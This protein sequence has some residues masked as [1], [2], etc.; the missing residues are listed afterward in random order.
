MKNYTRKN[1]APSIIDDFLNVSKCDR[2]RQVDRLGVFAADCLS[3]PSFV[4]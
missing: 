3:G 2:T 4:M 1:F